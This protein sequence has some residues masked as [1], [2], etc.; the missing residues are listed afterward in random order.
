HVH[1]KPERAPRDLLAD[2]A[3]TEHAE[4][5]AGQLDAAV[6]RPLP[7]AELE[8]GVRLRDVARERHQQ[9][10]RVLRGGD[11]RRLGRVRDDDAAACSNASSAAVT[12]AP[13]SM[14]APSSTSTI[15]T[16]ASA[17]V[18]SNTSNQPMWPIRKTLP[19]S[20]P[21]PSAIVIPNRSRS[22]ETTALDSTPSGER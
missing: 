19:L 21:W 10:D 5:L 7:A 9:P 11:D 17:V 16:A 2:P 18:M 20:G 15:S 14:S 4:P 12:A 13:R 8:R 22:A 3:E 6:R 1:A